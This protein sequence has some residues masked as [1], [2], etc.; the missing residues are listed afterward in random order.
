[1][2]DERFIFV[3]AFISFIGIFFYALS[4]LRGQTKPN[5]VTWSLWTIIP[6]ITFAA[7]VNENVGLVAVFSLAYAIGPFLVLLASFANK[8]AYWKLSSFDIVCGIISLLAIGLWL[9]TGDGVVAIALSVMADFAAGLPTL[10]KGYKAPKTENVSAFV[11]GIASA[12]ITLAT[13]H[14]W[15][16]ATVIFPMYILLDSILLTLTITVFSRY[17]SKA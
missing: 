7:Q 10:V 14:T 4:T 9:L 6:L 13:I 12:L 16:L 11:V 1:M 3:A 5:R 15:N 17:R 2:I 8:K